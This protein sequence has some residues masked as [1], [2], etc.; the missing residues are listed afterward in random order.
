MTEANLHD[1]LKEL[2]KGYLKKLESHCKDFEEL[3]GTLS[4]DNVEELYKKVHTIS[5]TAGM[6]GLKELSEFSTEFEMYLKT[7]RE[8]FNISEKSILEENFQKY[9]D[10]LKETI[11]TGD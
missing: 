6:Y 3:A 7:L 2:K 4:C 1:K 9:L 10:K 11:T 5:G 8:G